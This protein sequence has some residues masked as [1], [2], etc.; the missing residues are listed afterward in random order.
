MEN[1][2]FLYI[3][4]GLGVYIVDDKNGIFPIFSAF[5]ISKKVIIF[6]ISG[7]TIVFSDSGSPVH[8]E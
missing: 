2:I 4:F 7:Q 5:A 6:D 3:S 1:N 8:G